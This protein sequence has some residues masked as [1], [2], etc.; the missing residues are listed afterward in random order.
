MA[1]L[2]AVFAVWVTT[3]AAVEAVDV[4]T[5]T[6]LFTVLLNP[7]LIFL[8]IFPTIGFPSR[9]MFR[10]LGGS[11][12]FANGSGGGLGGGLGGGPGGGEGR[13]AFVLRVFFVCRPLLE[14]LAASTAPLQLSIIDEGVLMVA[15]QEEGTKEGRKHVRHVSRSPKVP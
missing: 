14:F 10:P 15:F 11:V 7:R 4:A 1:P 6:I 3:E 13:V 9:P 12:R 8:N 5:L 2:T